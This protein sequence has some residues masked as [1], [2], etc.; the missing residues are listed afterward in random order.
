M[1]FK[2]FSTFFNILGKTMTA[3]NESNQSYSLLV[4]IE[5]LSTLFL[6]LIICAIVGAIIISFHKKSRL[7]QEVEAQKSL[8]NLGFVE[9]LKRYDGTRDEYDLNLFE[10]I[11]S[12]LDESDHR[13][14]DKLNYDQ[15]NVGRNETVE[16]CRAPIL[17]YGPSKVLV[18]Y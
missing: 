8:N 10:F 16:P 12:D 1:I 14:Y 11:D 17:K 7:K 15:L 2:N 4:M 5:F 6:T 9:E 3:V 13:E 18:R